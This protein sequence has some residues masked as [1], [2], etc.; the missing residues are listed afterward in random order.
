[1]GLVTLSEA[2]ELFAATE[3]DLRAEYFNRQLRNLTQKGVLTPTSYRG[4]GRTAAALLDEEQLCRG[5]LLS[6]LSRIGLQPDQ[7]RRVNQILGGIWTGGRIMDERRWHNAM[8]KLSGGFRGV[9]RQTRAGEQWFLVVALGHHLSRSDDRFGELSGGFID[10]PE[11]GPSSWKP[12]GTIVLDAKDLLEPLLLEFDKM[13]AKKP[14]A[15]PRKNETGIQDTTGDGR[16]RSSPSSRDYGDA[17]LD[18]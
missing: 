15:E 2:A 16:S 5:R 9:I 8:E 4:S 12:L 10:M 1:M 3:P 13:I 18:P 17:R 6:V 11:F 14:N 7:L